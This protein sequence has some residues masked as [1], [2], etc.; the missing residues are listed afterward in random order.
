MSREDTGTAHLPP[1]FTANL[2][3]P[4]HDELVKLLRNTEPGDWD[5]P[6]VAGTWRVRDV[7][8][9]LLDIDLRK[10]S[11]SRDGHVPK[12][13][14][15][16]GGF[17]E[18]VKFLNGLNAEW[19]RA[20]RRLSPR[21]LI[22][23]LEVSGPAVADLVASLPPHGPSVFSVDWAG[24]RRSENWM[25]IGREY[26]ERWHH[27]MQIRDAVKAPGLTERRW[28]HPVLSLAVR[29]LPRAYGIVA[30]PDGTTV[31]VRIIG[32]ARDAWTLQREG[33]VWS[34]R[35]GAT[36]PSTASVR[37][38]ADAAWRLF[39][40]SPAAARERGVTEG[41]RALVEPF[42]TARAVMV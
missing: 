41:D 28:L 27:Q 40:N 11:T 2:F 22:E 42:F 33:G 18:L 15:A 19:V 8:A 10:L 25:D 31:A 34:L 14:S 29:S 24:E 6:T 3:G 23:L 12:P 4:L 20:A 21:V 1:L 9:H 30:A 35:H 17:E 39:F 37:L 16:A 5:R 13:E 36:S 26:T 32:D 38:D 7:V